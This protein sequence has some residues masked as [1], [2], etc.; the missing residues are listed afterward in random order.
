MDVVA[1]LFVGMRVAMLVMAVTVMVVAVTIVFMSL[2][3]ALSLAVLVIVRVI[4]RSRLPFH[5][6]PR[7][8]QA[9]A[10]HALRPDPVR[11]DGQRAEGAAHLVRRYAGIDQRADHHIAG[12]TREAVEIENRQT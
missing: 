9:R 11:C 7:G 6:E 4:D 3:T 8:T 12:D 5:A 1:H 10:R 2:G